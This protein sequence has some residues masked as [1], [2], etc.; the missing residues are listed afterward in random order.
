M[1]ELIQETEKLTAARE[2]QKAVDLKGGLA[3]AK[4]KGEKD[5]VDVDWQV[6]IGG[7]SEAQGITER[8]AIATAELREQS[9][10]LNAEIARQTSFE[11]F[12]PE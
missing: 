3:T 11:A 2:K 5:T 1:R 7:M 4:Q 8:L 6:K 10:L 12:D 9:T